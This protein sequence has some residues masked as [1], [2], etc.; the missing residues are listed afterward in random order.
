MTESCAM[1]KHNVKCLVFSYSGG[2]G[3]IFL[4]PFV[5]L[6]SVTGAPFS[7]NSHLGALQE[8]HH[9]TGWGPH[10][11]KSATGQAPGHVSSV[12]GSGHWDGNSASPCHI[13]ERDTDIPVSYVRAHILKPRAPGHL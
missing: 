1:I 3:H 2:N 12:C 7:R 11:P 4:F 13:G 5:F 6:P 10:V 8:A 9:N